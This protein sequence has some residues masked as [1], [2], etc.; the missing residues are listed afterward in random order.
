VLPP[1]AEVEE[2]MPRIKSDERP[3][4]LIRVPR[5]V[6]EWLEREAARTLA[7]Q[8]SEVVRCIRARMESE[9]ARAAN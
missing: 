3:T 9:Q 1:I 8:N 2:S 4:M 5:D 6:K 7:S